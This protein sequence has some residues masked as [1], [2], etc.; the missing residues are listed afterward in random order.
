M[1]LELRVSWKATADDNSTADM[2][3]VDQPCCDWRQPGQ[4]RAAGIGMEAGG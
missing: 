4:R 2:E 1:E 3:R